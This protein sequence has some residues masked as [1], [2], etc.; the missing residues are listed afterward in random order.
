[1]F[2]YILSLLVSATPLDGNV[3]AEFEANTVHRLEVKN[4]SG[5][6]DI[7]ALSAGQAVV[8]VQPRSGSCSP[9]VE[10]VGSVLHVEV[11]ARDAASLCEADVALRM[12]VALAQRIAIGSGNLKI[13]GTQGPLTVRAGSGSIDVHAEVTQLDGKI[14]SGDLSITGLTGP[15][16]L[17]VG[18][19]DAHLNFTAAPKPGALRL[20]VGSGDV[21]VSLPGG[22]SV[23]TR[24]VQGSGSFTNAFADAPDAAFLV[25]VLAGSGDIV[26][27][28]RLEGDLSRSAHYEPKRQACL[29]TRPV[30]A[31]GHRRSNS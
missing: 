29:M 20:R 30:S 27:R 7:Q 9:R 19:G 21:V 17:Q 25:D 8:D 23:R 26:L 10:L 3:H 12:P 24:V 31:T 1:M 13:T 14:G 2:A 18:S 11:R 4:G 5:R 16:S 22:T 15:G 28:R 6:V